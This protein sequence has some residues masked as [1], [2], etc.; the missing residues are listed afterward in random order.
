MC[1]TLLCSV[2]DNTFGLFINFLRREGR[3]E[4][5]KVVWCFVFD[6]KVGLR[7]FHLRFFHVVKVVYWTRSRGRMT[8]K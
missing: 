3:S 4:K 5:V 6:V 8:C 2:T 1:I 7:F